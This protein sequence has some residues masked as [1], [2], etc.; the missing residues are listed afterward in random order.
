[1]DLHRKGRDRVAGKKRG[2]FSPEFKDEAHM[3][4]VE[5]S[6]SS[7]EVALEPGLNVTT[8]KKSRH[9]CVLNGSQ[10]VA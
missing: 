1:M 8:L 10:R 6:R 5:D 7:A 3:M 4:V 9:M 2:N